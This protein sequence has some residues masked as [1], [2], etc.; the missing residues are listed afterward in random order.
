MTRTSTVKN[1]LIKGFVPSILY[2]LP[3]IGLI[4][5]YFYCHS[6]APFFSTITYNS[7]LSPM[8]AG[9]FSRIAIAIAIR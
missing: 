1:N 9:K 4:C 3:P 7:S 6:F 5:L 2:A 8:P